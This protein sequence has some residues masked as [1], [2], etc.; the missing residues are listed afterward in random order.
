MITQN[1]PEI[2]RQCDGAQALDPIATGTIEELL[3]ALKKRYTIII[4]THT[5]QQAARVSDDT[6]F[7][8]LGELIE[9]GPTERLFTAPVDQR[10]EACI[11]GRFG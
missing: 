6:G 10:T 7:L 5:M 1:T 4:V 8:L 3:Y 9:C 2:A 11:T